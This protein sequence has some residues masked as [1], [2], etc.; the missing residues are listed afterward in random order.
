MRRMASLAV[1]L[2]VVAI[3]TAAGPTTSSH[4]SC[5]VSPGG[6]V[7]PGIVRPAL[8]PTP[9]GARAPG[10][11]DVFRPG[12]NPTSHAL[13][14]THS[15][16]HSHSHTHALTDSL[17]LTHTLSRS[18]SHTHSPP[19]RPAR[20]PALFAQGVEPKKEA[21]GGKKRTR[22]RGGKSRGSRKDVGGKG[23]ASIL[24]L[25]WPPPLWV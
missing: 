2:A 5:F 3:A 4:M 19:G 7:S 20:L 12:D 23:Q 8:S 18:L 11:L 14:L 13:F 17:S 1:W 25:A 21:S 10:R 6:R 24:S 16:S 22:P 9:A 15:H